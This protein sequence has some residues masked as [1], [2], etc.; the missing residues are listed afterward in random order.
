MSTIIDLEKA[1]SLIKEYRKQ[2][3]AAGGPALVTPDKKP[4]HGFFIDRK[5][6]EHILSNPK[7]VGVAV[8]FAK[9]PDFVGEKENVFTVVYSGAEHAEAGAPAPYVSTGTCYTNPPPCPPFCTNLG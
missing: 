3:S 5:S 9:H 4:H 2:N 7:V 6:I 8:E 1:K